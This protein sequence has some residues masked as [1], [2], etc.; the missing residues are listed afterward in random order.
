MGR[1]RG[2]SG[3]V[4]ELYHYRVAPPLYHNIS[5]KHFEELLGSS[6]YLNLLHLT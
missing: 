4:L 6:T 5:D 3:E 2:M 1:D